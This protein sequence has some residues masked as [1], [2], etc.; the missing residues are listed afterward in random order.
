MKKIRDL[1]W[2]TP[3]NRIN[4]ENQVA[5]RTLASFGQRGGPVGGNS[6]FQ[7]PRQGRTRWTLE[8]LAGKL[9]SITQQD[10]VSRET[11]R[12]ASTA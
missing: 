5:L 10:S 11:V 4:T 12:P 7:A 2:V 9:V 6:V 8:L 1:V 3:R